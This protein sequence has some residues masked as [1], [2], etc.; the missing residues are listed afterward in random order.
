MAEVV[1]RKRLWTAGLEFDVDSAG[2]HDYMPGMPPF[3]L[4]VATA[5]RR[6]YDI[7]GVVSRR[8]R[9]HDFG[10]FDLILGMSRAHVAWLKALSP[11]GSMRKI[12]LLTEY[13]DEFRRKDIPDPYGGGAAGYELALGM[14]EDACDGV[15]RSFTRLAYDSRGDQRSSQA[16]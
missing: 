9:R 16:A 3:P 6:G 14:I 13:S 2:T 8:V 7:T 12:R 5:K 15:L 4:A 11:P 10:Y 1:L